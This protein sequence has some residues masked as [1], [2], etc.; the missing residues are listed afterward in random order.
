[1]RERCRDVFCVVL[2]EQGK[3]RAHF[4]FLRSHPCCSKFFM[5]A[6]QSSSVVQRLLPKEFD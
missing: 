3:A 5:A 1:M 2:I 6:L 4:N